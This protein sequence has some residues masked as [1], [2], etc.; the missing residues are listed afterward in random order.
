MSTI[1]Q[2]GAFS[3]SVIA[4]N[5]TTEM[6]MIRACQAAIP[7]VIIRLPK[8]YERVVS[9]IAKKKLSI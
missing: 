2:I 4:P 9:K 3:A 6:P 8:K 1:N 5:D 7:F